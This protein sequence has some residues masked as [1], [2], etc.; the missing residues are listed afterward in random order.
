MYV[1]GYCYCTVQRRVELRDKLQTRYAEP[2]HD[3]VTIA[4]RFPDG[5]KVEHKF[6]DTNITKVFLVNLN[7]LIRLQ[8]R[9]CISTCSVLQTLINLSYYQRCYLE[10]LYPAVTVLH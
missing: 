6:Y 10:R 8:Y 3:G 4:F 5:T 7:T 2:Q 9:G 1:C